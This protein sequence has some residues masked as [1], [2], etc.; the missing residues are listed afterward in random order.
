MSDP[1]NCVMG[2]GYDPLSPLSLCNLYGSDTL[3]LLPLGLK[4]SL[5][6]NHELLQQIAVQRVDVGPSMSA[7]THCPMKCTLAATV[8][9]ITC[10]HSWLAIPS[11]CYEKQREMVLRECSHDVMLKYA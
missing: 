7:L 5:T 6:F 9:S 8:P 1:E 2:F 3:R 11:K 4:T 10:M